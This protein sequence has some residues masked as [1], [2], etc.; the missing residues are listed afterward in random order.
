MSWWVAFRPRHDFRIQYGFSEGIAD[1]NTENMCVR[2]R[3]KGAENTTDITLNDIQRRFRCSYEH[4]LD[5][6][7]GT[8]RITPDECLDMSVHDAVIAADGMPN[9]ARIRSGISKGMMHSEISRMAV[10]SDSPK[11]YFK[12]ETG[13]YR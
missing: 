5:R 9:W 6:L 2:H 1:P 11:V 10:V 4:R 8:W 12:R 7:S 13:E 3:V